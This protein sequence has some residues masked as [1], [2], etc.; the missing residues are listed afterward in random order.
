MELSKTHQVAFE[1]ARQAGSGAQGIGLDNG[2]LRA[3]I[4]TVAE[5]L[6][7]ALD[8]IEPFTGDFFH[9]DP[10]KFTTG[11]GDPLGH[12]AQLIA[13]GPLDADMYFSA[14]AALHRARLKY[15]NILRVQPV[16]TLEQVGPR[17][18]PSTDS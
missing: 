9:T 3:I 11:G 2:A 5:D 1:K 6:V 18:L 7:I 15:Q 13:S 8:D 16:P 14:L 4:W 17:G 12:F 10:S